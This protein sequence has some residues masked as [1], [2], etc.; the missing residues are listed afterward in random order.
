MLFL[1]PNPRILR[2][3]ACERLLLYLTSRQL[4][5]GFE[6]YSLAMCSN[7]S[8]YSNKTSFVPFGMSGLHKAKELRHITAAMTK[9]DAWCLYLSQANYYNH[10][11]CDHSN[12]FLF[13]VHSSFTS[14]FVVCGSH[15]LEPLNH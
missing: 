7:L 8:F 12:Y 2:I 11:I 10:N 9:Q 13:I 5:R 6:I 14:L 1:C 3:L 15:R 4:D